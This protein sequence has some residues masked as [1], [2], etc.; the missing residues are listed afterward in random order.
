MLPTAR[1][2]VSRYQ[3]HRHYSGGSVDAIGPRQ[4]GD[5]VAERLGA[6]PGVASELATSDVDMSS[7]GRLAYPELGAELGAG[8]LR[9]REL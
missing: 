9:P 5:P 4:G 6:A 1:G 8:E 7:D 3:P 2:S